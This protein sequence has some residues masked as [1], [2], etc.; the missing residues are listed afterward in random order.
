MGAPSSS[1]RVSSVPAPASDPAEPPP[2]PDLPPR[3]DVGRPADS[4]PASG[5]SEASVPPDP[6]P[7]GSFGREEVF[8]QAR[9]SSE[10]TKKRFRVI[11]TNQTPPELCHPPA[12]SI[13]RFVG[14]HPK[15]RHRASLVQNDIHGTID[16]SGRG[17]RKLL[18]KEG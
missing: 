14:A 7:G 17:V 1:T 12:N 2:P 9:A 6:E 4:P 16:V 11:H 5:S 13:A 3:L 10:I 18:V 15:K 8:P